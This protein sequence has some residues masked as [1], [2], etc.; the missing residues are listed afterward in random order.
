M[1][2][3][4]FKRSE[5]LLVPQ[6]SNKRDTSPKFNSQEFPCGVE[7][8]SVQPPTWSFSPRASDVL[9]RLRAQEPL[10]QVCCCSCGQ[11]WIPPEPSQERAA[12]LNHQPLLAPRRSA[13][14]TGSLPLSSPGSASASTIGLAIGIP[15]LAL[16]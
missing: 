10:K 7:L 15:A 16:K 11:A 13:V 5:S 6:S 1:A 3:P 12:P 9:H 2:T 14:P 8:A 4:Y